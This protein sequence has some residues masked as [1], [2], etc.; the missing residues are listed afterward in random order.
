M[1]FEMRTASTASVTFSSDSW[2]RRYH[3]HNRI[4]VIGGHE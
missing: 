4:R 3:V 2:P 1:P